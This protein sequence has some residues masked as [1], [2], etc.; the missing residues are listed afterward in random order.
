MSEPEVAHVNLQ[1][2]SPNIIFTSSLYKIALG[3][4]KT[5]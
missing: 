2:S 1:L 4:P 3:I 5:K